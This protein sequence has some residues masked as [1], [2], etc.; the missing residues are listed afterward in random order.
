MVGGRMRRDCGCKPEFW[1]SAYG[2][3]IS[4]AQHERWISGE[5]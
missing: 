2:D 5:L 4:D 1:V 3:W